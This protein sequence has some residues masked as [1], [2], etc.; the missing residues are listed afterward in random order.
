MSLITILIVA[1]LLFTLGFFLVP[2][3][4]MTV[5]TSLSAVVIFAMAGFYIFTKFVKVNK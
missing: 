2:E 4:I 3:N 5:Y 1:V